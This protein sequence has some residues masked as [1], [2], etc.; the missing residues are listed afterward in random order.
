M[1]ADPSDPM[2]GL[3]EAVRRKPSFIQTIRAVA[4]SFFC[5]RR[6]AD[7]QQDVEQL[8]HQQRVGA[9]FARGCTGLATRMCRGLR[10]VDSKRR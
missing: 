6:A 3:R 7:D 9:L 8:N 1:S 10:V 5:V 2:Q 4:W